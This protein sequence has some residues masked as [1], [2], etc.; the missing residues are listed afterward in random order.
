VIALIAL[1]VACAGSATAATVIT[2]RQIANRSVSGA[3]LKKRTLSKAHFKAGVLPKAGGGKE[4][5]AGSAGPQGAPGPQ[6][7]AGQNG[8]AGP[9]G[10]AGPIGPSRAT[11]DQIATF[12]QLPA[13]AAPV[14]TILVA[15]NTNQVI[16]A[17]AVADNNGPAVATVVCNVTGP[18]ALFDKA[19]MKLGPQL[20][21]ELD[22]LTIALHGARPV[23]GSLFAAI[24]LNC[25]DGVNGNVQLTDVSLTAVQ[26]GT[27]ALQ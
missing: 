9:Q 17:K 7:P 16:T 18:G 10:P 6:G 23:D 27:L 19:F 2:G 5:P 25:G 11:H 26:V 22:R 20:D 13:S 12:G 21:G 8:A 15:A 14:A 1:V 4:G 24:T 3:D